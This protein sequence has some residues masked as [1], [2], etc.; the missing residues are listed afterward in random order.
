[1]CIM[2]EAERVL[3]IGY[4]VWYWVWYWVFGIGYCIGYGIGLV[5]EFHILRYCIFQLGLLSIGCTVLS[6]LLCVYCST[7]V[8]MTVL[9]ILILMDGMI[10]RL[11]IFTMYIE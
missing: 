6:G 2:R 1:M 7:V 3:G 10:L 8:L 5:G 11:S 4:W 9:Y